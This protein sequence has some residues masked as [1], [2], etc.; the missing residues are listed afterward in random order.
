MDHRPV[1]PVDLVG[2]GV[3]QALA[4]LASLVALPAS[5]KRGHCRLRMPDTSASII[6]SLGS[7][8]GQHVINAEK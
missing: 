3:S 5:A 7:Q 1:N 6:D 8:Q 2:P 4:S